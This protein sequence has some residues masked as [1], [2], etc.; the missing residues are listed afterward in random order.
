MLPVPSLHRVA[1]CAAGSFLVCCVAVAQGQL[2]VSDAVISE[3]ME[4]RSSSLSCTGILVVFSGSVKS[5]SET[6]PSLADPPAVPAVQMGRFY[7]SES[8]EVRLD[9]LSGPIPHPQDGAAVFDVGLVGYSEIITPDH[10]LIYSRS[11]GNTAVAANLDVFNSANDPRVGHQIAQFLTPTLSASWKVGEY[12]V[13]DLLQLS[14]VAAVHT[15]EGLVQINAEMKHA[16]DNV[17]Q[18]TV[19][20]DPKKDYSIV[21]VTDVARTG[22]VSCVHKREV[23]VLQAP[24]GS[25]IGEQ[26]LDVVTIEDPPMGSEVTVCRLEQLEFVQ[27]DS[28]VFTPQAYREFPNP[29]NQITH[30]SRGG[31]A[32]AGHIPLSDAFHPTPVVVGVTDSDS[33]SWILLCNIVVAMI[34]GLFVVRRVL[35]KYR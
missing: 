25:W 17:H 19:T 7:S 22:S 23:D 29:I 16:A 10:S 32:N 31:V 2:Q 34:V 3:M 11:P 4:H 24:N 8:G 26:F 6:A 18:I 14:G 27:P 30:D 5:S 35:F 12:S 15:A 13:A 20:V 21:R 9:M 33:R 1:V 28:A